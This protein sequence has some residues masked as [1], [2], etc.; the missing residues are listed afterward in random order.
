[1]AATPKLTVRNDAEAGQYELIAD[2]VV[3]GLAQY[4]ARP[5]QLAFVHTEI[6]PEVSGQGLGQVLIKA[7]LDDA[8]AKGLAVLPY[9]SFV[10]HYVET[11]PD[12]QDL[13]PAARRAAFGLAPDPTG[14]PSA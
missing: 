11:H 3:V 9:C 12:Y 8:R 14:T 5:G 10:R 7:A 4:Q 6:A 1:M 2:D 13:V